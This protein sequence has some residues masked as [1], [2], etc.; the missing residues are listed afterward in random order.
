LFQKNKNK[1][2]KIT[3]FYSASYNQS[4]KLEIPL[5]TFSEERSIKNESNLPFFNPH[6]PPSSITFFALFTDY[7]LLTWSASCRS[8]IQLSSYRASGQV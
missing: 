7:S 1:K 5:R 2:R 8:H 3:N 4:F 6:A